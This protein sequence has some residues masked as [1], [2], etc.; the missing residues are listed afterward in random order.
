M[1][2]SQSQSAKATTGRQS[3][4]WVDTSPWLLLT[5]CF[6]NFAE[7]SCKNAVARVELIQLN[8]EQ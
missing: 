7:V 6:D 5:S 2:L 4:R 1:A 3:R 8:S